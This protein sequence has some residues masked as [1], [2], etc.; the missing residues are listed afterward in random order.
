MNRKINILISAVLIL[1]ILPLQFSC[2]KDK[3]LQTPTEDFDPWVYDLNSNGQIDAD[4]LEAILND[5][6]ENKINEEEF[7]AVTELW[8]SHG[9]EQ[10][11]NSTKSSG[12]VSCLYDNNP[13]DGYI[14]TVELQKAISDW[15]ASIITTS[16]LQLLIHYW[17]NDVL[18]TCSTYDEMNSSHPDKKILGYI[19]LSAATPLLKVGI[20]GTILFDIDDLYG[21]TNDGQVSEIQDDEWMTVWFNPSAGVTIGLPIT[22]G[23]LLLPGQD[24]N[25]D[26]WFTPGL[27]FTCAGGGVGWSI[28]SYMPTIHFE[29][30]V[31]GVS[32]S[33]GSF[34]ALDIRK[35]AVNDMLEASITSTLVPGTF[36]DEISTFMNTNWVELI[37]LP[38]KLN[39]DGDVRHYSMGNP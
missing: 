27:S 37:L 36:A 15:L 20:T 3:L 10:D 24:K 30:T 9:T 16:D 35:S 22:V 32:V 33:F 34:Y 8:A 31:A 11:E 25:I 23:C 7:K 4:E 21:V 12:N 19:S 13:E 5:F 29:T 17:L 1:L 26:P 39:P 6:A 38:K 14:G 2:N 28:G 18:C